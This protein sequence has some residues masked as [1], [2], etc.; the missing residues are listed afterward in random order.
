MA[1]ILSVCNLHTLVVFFFLAIARTA[2]GLNIA[3]CSSDNTGSTFA[4]GMVPLLGL[5]LMFHAEL[6]EPNQSPIISNRMVPASRPALGNMPLQSFAA[7]IA[8]VPIMS[9]P[10]PRPQIPA[11]NRV[12]GIL[13][14]CAVHLRTAS[15]PTSR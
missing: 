1:G 7:P 12:P 15:L 11:I 14:T 3:Y 10:P 8:G 2:V 13:Q 6:I 4:E 9:Q 5:P